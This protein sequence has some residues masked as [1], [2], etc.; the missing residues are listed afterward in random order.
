MEIVDIDGRQG[1]RHQVSRGPKEEREKDEARPLFRCYFVGGGA[2]ISN[3]A[4]NEFPFFSRTRRH[5]QRGVV[6]RRSRRR[7]RGTIA[8]AASDGICTQQLSFPR[9]A[10]F[11]TAPRQLKRQLPRLGMQQQQQVSSQLFRILS[12][13]LCIPCIL[14]HRRI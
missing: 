11:G 10:V 9:L 5:R 7:R 14:H 12:R 6:R 1:S 13:N 3:L 4:T 2:S 8:M